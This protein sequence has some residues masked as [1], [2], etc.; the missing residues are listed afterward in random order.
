MSDAVI[1]A[2]ITTAG[3]IF[4][5]A[6]TMWNS[7]RAADSDSKPKLKKENEALRKENQELKEVIDYYRKRAK[8]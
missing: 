1:V 2:L 8:K 4:V 7:S 6:L 3:S 5:A